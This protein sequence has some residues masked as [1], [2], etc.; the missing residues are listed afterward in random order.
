MVR[1]CDPS[2]ALLSGA[3]EEGDL[4]RAR[5]PLVNAGCG[6]LVNKFNACDLH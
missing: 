3:G 2:A 4:D 5:S 1:A 6:S